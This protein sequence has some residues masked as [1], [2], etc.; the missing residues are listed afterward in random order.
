MTGIFKAHAYGEPGMGGLTESEQA[1]VDS[2]VLA[3]VDAIRGSDTYYWLGQRAIDDY[4][5]Y[6]ADCIVTMVPPKSW[7]ERESDRG[8]ASC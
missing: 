3:N 6:V 1:R 5:E 7:A 8:D 4:T 2:V